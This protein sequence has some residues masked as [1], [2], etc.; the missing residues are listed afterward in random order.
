MNYKASGL[1][2]SILSMKLEFEERIC[3]RVHSGL[4]SFWNDS[5]CGDMLLKDQFPSFY[6]LDRIRQRE[7]VVAEQFQV[8]EEKLI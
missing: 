6:S 5:W 1:W 3:N 2:K 4:L 7:V 8:T